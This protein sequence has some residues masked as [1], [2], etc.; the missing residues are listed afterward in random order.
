MSTLNSPT[1]MEEI[2]ERVKHLG[3]TISGRVRLY[4][5]EF[6]VMSEPF[7]E[8]DGIAVRAKSRRDPNVR[9][10]HLPATVMQTVKGNRKSR[11]APK[12]A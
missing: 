5:E 8:A 4:G 2:C 9:I 11:E 3:Y 10:L 12:L 6:E 7:Q 1:V